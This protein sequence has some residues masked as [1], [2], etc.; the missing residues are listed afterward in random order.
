MTDL[1]YRKVEDDRFI[2]LTEWARCS[3]DHGPWVAGGSVRKIWQGKRFDDGDIDFFFR[4]NAQLVEVSGAIAKLGQSHRVLADTNN[5]IT[6]KIFFGNGETTTIQLIRKNFYNDLKELLYTFDLCLSQFA[7]DSVN[8]VAMSG[9]LAD[10]GHNRI[11]LN[12]QF[13]DRLNP[14]RV[15][16]YAAYGFD[17]DKELLINASKKIATGDLH[18]LGY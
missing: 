18:D 12:E 3:L 7:S 4:N 11:R 17:P 13:S 8:M 9:A 1:S 10:L 14:L 6:Y 16:K 2:F 15:L 5:A